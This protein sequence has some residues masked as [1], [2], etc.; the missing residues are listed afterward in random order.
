MRTDHLA[1]LLTPAGQ[2]DMGFRQGV[3]LAW[4]PQLGTNT[5]DV[6]GTQL[7][8]LPTLAASTISLA[9]GD[10]VGLIR[11]KSTY[12]IAG[13]IAPAGGGA[14]ATRSAEVPTQESTTSASYVNLTTAGPSVQA[15]IGGSRQCLV[16]VQASAA[17]V[18]GVASCAAYVTGASTIGPTKPA[19]IGS[20]TTSQILG[21]VC[22][23]DLLTAND[24]LNP[25]LN[26]FT[27]KYAKTSGGGADS[28]VFGQRTITVIPF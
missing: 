10:V 7:D 22:S 12:F 5:I 4:D 23:T 14:L 2:P 19:Y 11:F 13:R 1:P 26:T 21:S 16:I 20:N 3:V 15:Y 28:A 6:G 27:V 24:G 17:I 25:G 8:N 9:V 18:N